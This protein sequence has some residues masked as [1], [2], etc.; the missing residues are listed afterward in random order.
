MVEEK[1]GLFEA[2][3][4]DGKEAFFFA[5][6]RDDKVNAKE[7]REAAWSKKIRDYKTDIIAR[8]GEIVR[9]RNP[10][11]DQRLDVQIKNSFSNE[12]QGLLVKYLRDPREVY[13]EAMQEAI[14]AK[15]EDSAC[16]NALR[17]PSTQNF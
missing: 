17:A 16:S 7:K 13:L 5:V 2:P 6:F 8:Q 4:V 9:Q 14:K 15:R 3:R 11:D 1:D 10:K 12:L